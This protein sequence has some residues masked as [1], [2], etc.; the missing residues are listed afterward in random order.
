MYLTVVLQV[1]SVA[2]R[3]ATDITSV[4]FSSSVSIHMRTQCILVGKSFATDL[5]LVYIPANLILV[6]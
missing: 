5:T 1:I 3:L 6:H 2:E 4:T